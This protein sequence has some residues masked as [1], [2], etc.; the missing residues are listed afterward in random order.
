MT[1]Q[2][3][4]YRNEQAGKF[5]FSRDTMRFWGS[6][7]G[8][9]VYEGPGGVYFTTSEKTFDG[10]GRVFSVRQAHRGGEDI[11]TALSGLESGREAAR[12]A[13]RLAKGE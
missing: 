2:Q 10:K 5:F 4:K 6:R 9:T 13:K 3:I 12:E 7:I 11:T 8:Q 1:I